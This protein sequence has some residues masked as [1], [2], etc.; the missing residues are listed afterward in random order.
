MD[1]F[2]LQVAGTL[3][4]PVYNTYVCKSTVPELYPDVLGLEYPDS[5]KVCRH[6]Q[7]AR[8]DLLQQRGFVP[9]CP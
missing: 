8:L 7:R 4:A 5:D 3:M 9:N 6:H 1:H 2:K